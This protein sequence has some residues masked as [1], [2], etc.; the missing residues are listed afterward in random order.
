[1]L[2]FVGSIRPTAGLDRNS[3]SQ[4]N[5]LSWREKSSGLAEARFKR[6]ERLAVN[7]ASRS[8]LNL[9]P[10]LCNPTRD[11]NQTNSEDKFRANHAAAKK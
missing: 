8:S 4:A 1:M 6:N 5:R 2:A 7:R 3:S 11:K 9:V 10:V